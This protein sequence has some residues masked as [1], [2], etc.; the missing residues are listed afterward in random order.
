MERIYQAYRCYTDADPEAPEN[1]RMVNMIFAGQNT[2]DIRRKLQKLDGEFGMN[3]FQLVDIAF[4]VFNSREQKQK[5]EDARQNA[6][7]LAATLDF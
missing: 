4:N 2:S 7:F 3:P 6:T 1:A 5:K